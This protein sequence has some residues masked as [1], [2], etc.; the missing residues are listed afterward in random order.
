M[1]LTLSD[2]GTG[3]QIGHRTLLTQVLLQRDVQSAHHTLLPKLHNP[4]KYDVTN[5]DINRHYNY[6]LHRCRLSA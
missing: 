5:V 3:M 1:S 6:Q 4:I 2:S